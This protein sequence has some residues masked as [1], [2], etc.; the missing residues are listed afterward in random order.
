METHSSFRWCRLVFRLINSF[1]YRLPSGAFEPDQR[2]VYG[3]QGKVF[4]NVSPE[5]W[6]IIGKTFG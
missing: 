6:I 1:I 3:R 5:L 2:P 4:A